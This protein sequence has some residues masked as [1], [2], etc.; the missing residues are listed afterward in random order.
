[1]KNYKF[2]IFFLAL[3]FS[4]TAGAVLMGDIFSSGKQE[5]PSPLT[6]AWGEWGIKIAAAGDVNND[7]YGD[8]LILGNLPWDNSND[9]FVYL[10]LGSKDGLNPDPLLV[11]REDVLSASAVTIAAAGDVDADGF[12][13]V[14]I[15]V[16]FIA[17]SLWRD[18]AYLFRGC[19]GGLENTAGWETPENFTRVGAVNGAGDVNGDGYGDVLISG[20]WSPDW[21]YRP[22]AIY[23]FLGSR[24]GLSDE[25]DDFIDHE[26]QNNVY[27]PD[28]FI[29]A[30]DVNGDGYDDIVVSA[31]RGSWSNT[32]TSSE[33]LFLYRGNQQGIDDTPS[34]VAR[35]WDERL[36]PMAHTTLAVGE[37]NGDGHLDL[38]YGVPLATP[39]E[40]YGYAGGAFVFYGDGEGFDGDRSWSYYCDWPNS[41]MGESLAVADIT[42]DGIEDLAV[43]GGQYA[44]PNEVTEEDAF[45]KVMVFKGST[46]GLPK[47]PDETAGSGL[48][49]YFGRVMAVAGDVNGDGVPDIA[50]T[51]FNQEEPGPMDKVIIYLGKDARRT[52]TTAGPLCL[53]QT[54]LGQR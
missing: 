40:G 15:G 20:T 42:G 30:G 10:Y 45:G 52:E 41:Y 2:I 33:V 53:I 22:D 27:F 16:P 48:Q 3:L 21:E 49:D 38:A 37:L 5:L 6:G 23:L 8:V 46:N 35:E 17:G 28:G 31:W 43:G 36:F 39:S 25:P 18:K 7:G 54:L 19:A 11:L 14:V 51:S 50:V 24:G 47:A 44:M 32:D 29:P 4:A 9:A 13:D 1:M 12:D 34:W 26:T